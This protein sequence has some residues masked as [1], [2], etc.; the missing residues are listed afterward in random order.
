[1]HE[2]EILATPLLAELFHLARRFRA[3]EMFND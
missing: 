2:R 1:M 3:K